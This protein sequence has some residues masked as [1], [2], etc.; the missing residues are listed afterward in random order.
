MTRRRCWGCNAGEC[1]NKKGRLRFSTFSGWE[2]GKLR[3]SYCMQGLGKQYGEMSR[4]V[5]AFKVYERL[6]KYGSFFDRLPEI[7][8]QGALSQW[9]PDTIF[10]LSL[11]RPSSLVWRSPLRTNVKKAHSRA[12]TLAFLQLS[13][14]GKRGA[15]SAQKKTEQ[16]LRPSAAGPPEPA[17]GGGGSFSE[18]PQKG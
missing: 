9:I 7:M 1:A 12:R 11:T 16:Q 6:H 5:D 13:A 14:C 8:G 3:P 15:R 10:S 18:R 17:G 2:W 4:A